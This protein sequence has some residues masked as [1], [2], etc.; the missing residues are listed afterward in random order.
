MSAEDTRELK[1]P[2]HLVLTQALAELG[3][4]YVHQQAAWAVKCRDFE[5]AFEI[6]REH[7][8]KN[9]AEFMRAQATLTELQQNMDKLTSASRELDRQ[10]IATMR[11]EQRALEIIT[12]AH[13]RLADVRTALAD[14]NQVAPAGKAPELEAVEAALEGMQE[15]LAKLA[16]GA[17]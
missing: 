8:L 16:E 15:V 5:E 11:G 1:V 14:A 3:H 13:S 10:H 4:F 6:E 7:A 2:Q 9:G 17:S 12:E